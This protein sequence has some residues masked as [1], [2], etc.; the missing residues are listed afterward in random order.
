MENRASSGNVFDIIEISGTACLTKCSS[1][2]IDIDHPHCVVIYKLFTIFFLIVR[3]IVPKKCPFFDH[4]SRY[5]VKKKEF[6][7]I[8]LYQEKNIQFLFLLHGI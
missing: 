1:K 3:F 5:I 4:L 7:E 6:S 8:V 2:R